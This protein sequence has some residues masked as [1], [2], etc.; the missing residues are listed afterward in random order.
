MYTEEITLFIIMAL[1][2]SCVNA[3]KIQ[4]IY[5]LLLNLKESITKVL[6]IAEKNIYIC[7]C[8]IN[9]ENLEFSEQ[10]FANNS[11]SFDAVKCTF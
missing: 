2:G 3:S 1:V 8:Y 4:I 10:A 6:K 5:C 9:P 7:I 11:P